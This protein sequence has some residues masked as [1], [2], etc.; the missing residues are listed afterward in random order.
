MVC[1]QPPSV[2]S[3]PI[4]EGI[5]ELRCVDPAGSVVQAARALGISF[6][7]E[8]PQ[9]IVFAGARAESNRVHGADDSHSDTREDEEAAACLD[10][11]Q[12]M[13]IE[14]VAASVAAPAFSPAPS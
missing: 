11:L 8:D 5:R 14:I 4:V 6:G 12:N 1:Y 13:S 7:D 3:V 10:T 2:C 9:T